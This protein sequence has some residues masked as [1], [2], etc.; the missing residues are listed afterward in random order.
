MDIKVGTVI[1]YTINGMNSIGV[2]TGISRKK[3]HVQ[4]KVKDD[5]IHLIDGP[6][7][8]FSKSF[9]RNSKFIAVVS[10]QW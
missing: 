9:V 1:N 6:E 4:W 3:A 8:C 7:Y 2:I 10:E 5:Q